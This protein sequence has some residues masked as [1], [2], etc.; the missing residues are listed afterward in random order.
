MIQARIDYSFSQDSYFIY[1]LFKLY[2][3]KLNLSQ[4]LLA[5]FCIM[6]DNFLQIL[7]ETKIGTTVTEGLKSNGFGDS[8]LSL[9]AVQI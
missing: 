6:K 5:F 2:H 8:V 9:F 3:F 4:L 7:V 1:W